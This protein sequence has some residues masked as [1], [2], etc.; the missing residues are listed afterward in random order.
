MPIFGKRK[1]RIETNII[2]GPKKEICRNLPCIQSNFSG[3]PR[4]K[5][6][7]GKGTIVLFPLFLSPKKHTNSIDFLLHCLLIE[8]YFQI[9]LIRWYFLGSIE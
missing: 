2:S 8:T 9:A 1:I 7:R 5:T 4:K 6:Q 3:Y